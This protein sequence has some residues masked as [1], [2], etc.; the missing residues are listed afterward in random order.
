MYHFL[1]RY[2]P[3]SVALGVTALAYAVL[4]FLIIMRLDIYDGNFRYLQI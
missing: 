1:C 2:L 3:A 4:L